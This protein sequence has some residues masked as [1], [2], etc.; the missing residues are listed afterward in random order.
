MISEEENLWEDK[1]KAQ[2]I[3]KEKRKLESLL[4]NFSKLLL[5]NG[6]K[7]D[8]LLTLDIPYEWEALY[9]ALLS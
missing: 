3:F 5:K 2:S 6:Y 9:T 7:S 4:N 1:E 8:N